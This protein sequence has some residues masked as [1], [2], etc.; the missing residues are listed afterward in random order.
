MFG[1]TS[2]RYLGNEMEVMSPFSNESKDKRML[3]HQHII[4]HVN[5]SHRY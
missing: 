1:D 4:F 2:L 3:P 5:I